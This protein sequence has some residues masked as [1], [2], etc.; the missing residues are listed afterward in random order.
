MPALKVG[1]Q[2]ASLRLPFPQALL[3]AARLGAGAVEIDARGSIR[4]AELTR[5]A[6]RQLRKMLDDRNL[7]VAA[8]GFRTRRGY[9]VSDGL[10]ARVEATRQ[11]MQMAYSLGAP[12][13]VNHVGAVP[14]ESQGD[15]WELLVQVLTDLGR[16]GQ[17]VGAT[18]AAETGTES[19]ADLL[20]LIEALPPGSLTVNF[21]PGNLIV[22]GYSVREAAQA[23]GPH[24]THVHAKDAVPDVAQGRGIEV[25]LGRGMADFVEL[26]A[27]L[28]QQGYAGWW[29][30][31]RGP[32]DDPVGEIAQAVAYLRNL[33]EM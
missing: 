13:V 12:V 14:T 18:L 30:I 10:D 19:G 1:I 8:V 9:D 15:R 21:D 33:Y 31:E 17:K 4:P 2:L 28:E 25:P 20:R 5:T 16:Y 7:R 24:V 29:T 26:A 27:T 22:G 3:T 6:V 32:C 11:A 23:L